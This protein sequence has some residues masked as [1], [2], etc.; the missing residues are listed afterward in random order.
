MLI[1]SVGGITREHIVWYCFSGVNNVIA[2]ELGVLTCHS[3]IVPGCLRSL[4][5]F[6]HCC[7]NLY[8]TCVFRG[9]WHLASSLPL[10]SILL[11]FRLFGKDYD[12]QAYVTLSYHSCSFA[13]MWFLS[14]SSDSDVTNTSSTETGSSSANKSCPTPSLPSMEVSIRFVDVGMDRWM[15]TFSFCHHALYLWLSALPLSPSRDPGD[16]GLDPEL[17]G[18]EG[19]GLRPGE[20]R[21]A[22]RP[23]EPCLYLY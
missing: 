21:P 12:F 13:L 6:V 8:W 17:S 22:Q 10:Y 15:E 16:E 2:G 9:G 20:K 23:P 4:E 3:I 19:G 7:N 18:E 5:W 1:W 11:Q 14:P